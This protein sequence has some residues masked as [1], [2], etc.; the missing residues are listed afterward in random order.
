MD[1]PYQLTYSAGQTIA[2]DGK[3][4]VNKANEAA[5]DQ[6]VVSDS[7]ENLSVEASKSLLALRPYF[8]VDYRGWEEAWHMGHEK[9][10]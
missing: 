8:V 2:F 7:E 5:L 6:N 10:A 3:V 1:L 9:K 4:T